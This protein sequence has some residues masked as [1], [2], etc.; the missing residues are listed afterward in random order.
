[1]FRFTRNHLQ[2]KL[3]LLNHV[4]IKVFLHYW[5]TYLSCVTFWVVHGRMAFNNRRFGTLC[6]FHLHRQVDVK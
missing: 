2:A 6:L 4:Y 1:M 3:Q 5:I